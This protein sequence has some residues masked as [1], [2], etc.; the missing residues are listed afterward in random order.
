LADTQDP[1]VKRA[2][3]GNMAGAVTRGAF[4]IP[5]FFPAGEIYFGRNRLHNV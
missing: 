3:T 2:L 1:K 4:G 5:T